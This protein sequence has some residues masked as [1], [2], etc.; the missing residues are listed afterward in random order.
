VTGTYGRD[1]DGNVI[2][3][4]EICDPQHPFNFPRLSPKSV[5]QGRS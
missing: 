1:P 2:E 3:I 4:L 5:G